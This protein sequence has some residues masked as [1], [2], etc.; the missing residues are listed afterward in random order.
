MTTPQ[1]RARLPP[2]TIS[3][4]APTIDQS[5]ETTAPLQFNLHSTYGPMVIG[6]FLVCILFGMSFLQTIVYWVNYPKDRVL[7][8]VLVCITR[9]LLIFTVEC[10]L[11]MNRR[12]RSR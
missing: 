3:A 10:Q 5:M 8:K 12:C 9:M 2:P 6:A 7:L 11:M 4:M 1:L